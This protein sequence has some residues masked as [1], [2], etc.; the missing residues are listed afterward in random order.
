[1]AVFIG[2]CCIIRRR[3]LCANDRAQRLCMC[4]E[5][6]NTA[7]DVKQKIAT[8]GGRTQ[9]QPDEHDVKHHDKHKSLNEVAQQADDGIA[10]A[11][12]Q[13]AHGAVVDQ[14]QNAGRI[15][16]RI[17]RGSGFKHVLGLKGCLLV[18]YG[19]EFLLFS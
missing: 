1:M 8:H 11:H 17:A 19:I 5:Q 7:H 13:I 4:H 12:P 2:E 18:P 3:A 9:V 15:D 16:Q 10:M 6:E 14:F